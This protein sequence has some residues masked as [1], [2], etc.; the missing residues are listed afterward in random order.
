MVVIRSILLLGGI[1][2]LGITS[3]AHADK[4]IAKVNGQE[5][6]K[7]ELD[8]IMPSIVAQT[9]MMSNEQR[10]RTALDRL[11]NMQL[12]FDQAV[13]EGIDKLAD[14]I[15]QK[16]L[17]YKQLL[18]A[19]YI[20]L[21]IATTISDERLKKEYKKSFLESPPQKEWKVRHIL[22]KTEKEAK[23]I[24]KKLDEGEEFAKLAKDK[25]QDVESATRGGDLGYFTSGIMVKP[26]EEAVASTKSGSYTDKP[27]ETPFG[28]HVIKVEDERRKIPPTFESTKTELH[29]KMVG[30]LFMSK[31]SELREAAKIEIDESVIPPEKENEEQNT[32]R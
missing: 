9:P 3:S 2:L 18:V 6:H 16:E 15:H 12:V 23:K 5:I 20:R 21:T 27:V 28:F 29:Q 11:V 17:L 1:L 26:F 31:L 19:E 22:V 30:E 32:K 25:S 14:V 10:I 13:E 4:V 24:I 8:A 7:S